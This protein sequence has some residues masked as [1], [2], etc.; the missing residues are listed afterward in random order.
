MQNNAS[1]EIN[2]KKL[3]L[4]VCYTISRT[5]DGNRTNLMRNSKCLKVLDISNLSILNLYYYQHFV[6]IYDYGKLT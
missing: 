5:K 2:L 1:T 6:Y 4:Y 3:N